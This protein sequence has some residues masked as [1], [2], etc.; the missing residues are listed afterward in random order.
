MIMH[1]WLRLACLLAV[2]LTLTLAATG[3]A[4]YIRPDLVNIPVATLLAN[5]EKQ[6]EKNSKSVEARFNLARAH[7]MAYAQKSPS[8][9]VFK[10][11][12]N[13][14]FWFGYEPKHIPFEVKK[15]DDPAEAKEAKEQLSK[16]IERYRE[17]VK[18]APKN[19]PAQLGLAWT[20]DQAGENK[21]AVKMYR[22]IVE[23]AWKKESKMQ[24]APLGWHSIVG[25]AGS[26]L[27]RH[28]DPEK[29]GKEIAALTEKTRQLSRIPRPV[30]PIAIP[31]ADQTALKDIVAPDARVRFDA[32]GSGRDVRWS[33]IS[34]KAAWL[35]Y[36][37]QQQGRITSALQLFGNVSFW[38]FWENGYH[39]LGALDANLDGKLSGAELKNLSLWHDRNGNGI[40]EP[41]EVQSLAVHGI[42]E[43][44]CRY[45][46]TQNTPNVAAFAEQGV[47]FRDGSTRPTY[48]VILQQ[49]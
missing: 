16:A 47:V 3:Q 39:A 9:Q 24:V 8:A 31:L 28:L 32:D 45:Q 19:F 26:Y 6:V 14:G 18:M 38:M 33:W 4:R 21:E 25:E 46:A 36:D 13:K 17:V 49:R 1:R 41:G 2:T 40:S 35:V 5:L 11:K 10:G 15:S 7:A 23:D 29:D 27:K 22:Q 12:E 30:T 37:Q 48:D 20:L 44:N 43:I 42:V 34:N